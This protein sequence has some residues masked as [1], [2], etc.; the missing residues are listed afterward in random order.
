M[1]KKFWLGIFLLFFGFV[2]VA[3]NPTELTPT[4]YTIHV[5]QAEG[6]TISVGVTEALPGEVVHIG[7]EADSGMELDFVRITHGADILEMTFFTFVMPAGDV[8]VEVGFKEIEVEQTIFEITIL[9][10]LHGEIL[11]DQES[12]F[13]EA[14][15]EVIVSVVPEAGY[16]Y[17]LGSLKYSD[18]ETYTSVQSFTFVMPSHDISLSANFEQGRTFHIEVSSNVEEASVLIVGEGPYAESNLYSVLAEG[19]LGYDFLYW[20]DTLTGLIVSYEAEYQ[21]TLRRNVSYEAVYVSIDKGM[22]HVYANTTDAFSPY[23]TESARGE[24]FSV[25]APSVEGIVFSHWYDYQNSEIISN[26]QTLTLEIDRV[27]FVIA[28]YQTFGEESKLFTEGFETVSKT[29][30]AEAVVTA[31]NRQWNLIESLIGTSAADL[32]DGNRSIRM[33]VPGIVELREGIENISKVTFLYGTYGTDTD[34]V[35]SLEASFDGSTWIE[36][37]RADTIGAMQLFEASFSHAFFANNQKS[38]SDAVYIRIRMLSGNRVNIDEVSIYTNTQ[39]QFA[40]PIIDQEEQELVF[41]NESGRIQINFDPDFNPYLSYGDV[42]DPT[43]CQ[44]TD[45]YL[46][47]QEC[48]V[49]GYVDTSRLGEYEVTYYVLDIDGLYASRTITKVVFRD[50][51]LLE[52]EYE[53]YYSGI[54]GLYGEELVLALRAILNDSIVRTSYDEARQVL[55]N[56]DVDPNDPTKVLTIYDRQ[57]VTRVWDAETWHREHVWPN[58]RLG[59]PRVTGSQRNIGSDLHNL[60]A[61]IPSVNS[62]RG[63][64]VFA[65]TETAMTYFPGHQ[66]KGDVARMMFYMVIMYEELT[67]VNDILDSNPLTNYT[68]AGAYM[69]VLN[70]LITWHFEDEV[71]YFETN[72]NQVIFD[73]Q[74]NRNPFIDHPHLVELV[75]FDHANLPLS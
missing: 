63:N 35:I 55:A 69:S 72:R 15:T 46:G 58:S 23:I 30:Y 50:A 14:G 8:V 64:K 20:K 43:G 21:F 29:A 40:L 51:S 71:D 22:V 38:R 59:I 56:A 74:K 6:G 65:L 73:A 11:I 12:M 33:R 4:K 19:L 52:I 57:S 1:F 26:N 53:G 13:V 67:L 3:C 34:G 44:A 49:Y 32:R 25:E 66:D 39:E 70:H 60:R 42:W 18:G 75:W 68:P 2:L 47:P 24:S 7:V 45:I 17:K 61:I 41:P 16:R 5:I 36:M 10:T 28:V 62:S 9:P 27:H 31:N 48:Q 54:S 37:G